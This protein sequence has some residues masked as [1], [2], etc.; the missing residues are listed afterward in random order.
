MTIQSERLGSEIV[1]NPKILIVDDKIDNVRVLALLL[2]TQGY[3][4]TFALNA[5]DAL[6]RLDIIQP[7]L[8]LLDL[9]M[10]DMNGLELCEHIKATPNLQDIP[11]IFLTASHDEQ[12]VVQAFEQGAADYM[13]KPFHAREV[14]TRA[15]IHIQLRRQTIQLR[16][17]REHLNTIVTHV[18]DGLLVLDQQGKIQ[19][20]NPAA[21]H[22]FK[23]QIDT[24]VDHQL[25]LP[26]VENHLTQIEILRL[27]GETGIAE[28]TVAPAIW[29]DQPASIVCLRDTSD[30][31]ALA[32]PQY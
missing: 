14:L 26:I 17:A 4:I 15:S 31:L 18:Q 28:I 11:I 30:R 32:D 2:E 1:S 22:M 6:K 7:D 13:T 24:L 12:H 21:A 19:F 8:I 20:A 27:N 5:Q 10:P 25:G 16:Q 3:S 29:D 23:R 9:F